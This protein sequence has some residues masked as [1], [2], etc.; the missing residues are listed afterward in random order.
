M[1]GEAP[2]VAKMDIERSA[3]RLSLALDK[4]QYNGEYL[5]KQAF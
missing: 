5:P 4:R 3:F 1:Q 2:A